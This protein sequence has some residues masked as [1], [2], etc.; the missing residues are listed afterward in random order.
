MTCKFVSSAHIPTAAICS[1]SYSHHSGSKL[2]NLTMYDVKSLYR[3][4]RNYAL[5]VSEIEAKVDEATNDD[6][7]YVVSLFL[8]AFAQHER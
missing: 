2:A 7:W 3:S 6:P 1:H 5:N 4:A 8:P